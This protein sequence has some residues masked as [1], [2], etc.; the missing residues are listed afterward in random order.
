MD[1]GNIIPLLGI[2]YFCFKERKIP[3]PV[4]FLLLLTAAVFA[5]CIPLSN[6]VSNRYFLPVY[7]FSLPVFVLTLSS[8]GRVPAIIA[9]LLFLWLQVQSLRFANPDKYGNAWDCNLQSLPYFELREQLDRYVTQNHINPAEVA[10]GFQL[11]FNDRYYLMDGGN[12]EYALLSDTEM[13]Q[14]LYV[15]DSN[16]CNN[17]NEQRLDYL[18]KN[19]ALI[20]SFERGNIYI[21]LYKRIEGG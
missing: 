21:R 6:P 4:L 9:C 3:E 5:F 1:F 11:Y 20:K 12:K 17:Y 16:I 13:P 19:Y 14:C 10:A 7:I 15:A 2:G 8:L 18:S